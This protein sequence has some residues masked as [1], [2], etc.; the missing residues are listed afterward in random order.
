MA[1]NNK[2]T[3][4]HL[5]FTGAFSP[6]RTGDED[7]SSCF[8]L[9]TFTKEIEDWMKTMDPRDEAFVQPADHHLS[10]PDYAPSSP[11]LRREPPPS[12]I[13]YS[14]SMT[15]E[16]I[17]T[18]SSYYAAEP[19]P[20]RSPPFQAFTASAI[21][22][23]GVTP[24][25]TPGRTRGV[26]SIPSLSPKPTTKNDDVSVWEGLIYSMRQAMRLQDEQIKA[27]KKENDDLRR[28][29]AQQQRF[30]RE[31]GRHNDVHSKTKVSID[32]FFSEPRRDSYPQSCN[33]NFSPGTKFVAELAQ[34]MEVQV[35]QFAALSHIM[36]K[37]LSAES[38]SLNSAVE[39]DVN[40]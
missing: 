23:L 32:D 2:D 31:N 9:S 27:L 28:Q 21:P 12:D 18:I 34:L 11:L 19:D 5:S 7:A 29:I 4:G 37:R 38:Q 20:V 39:Q 40:H 36:D 22:S 24:L 35:G 1:A 17:S 30:G 15:D 10:E 3:D 26:D 33:R 13:R 6:S 25:T 14:L 16:K 8:D